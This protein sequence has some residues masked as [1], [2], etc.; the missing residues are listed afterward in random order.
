MHMGVTYG[1]FDP[2]R[3]IM[4]DAGLGIN[5]AAGTNVA[6]PLTWRDDPAGDSLHGWGHLL[7]HVVHVVSPALGPTSAS[8]LGACSRPWCAA[9][10]VIG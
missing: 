1:E 5:D 8:Q 4:V 9:S 6:G 3:G 2:N 7:E 10:Q